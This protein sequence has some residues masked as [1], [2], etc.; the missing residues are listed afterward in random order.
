MPSA[1]CKETGPEALGGARLRADSALSSLGR[2][3]FGLQELEQ[4]I[5]AAGLGI[6]AGHVEAAEGMAADQGAGAFA[7]EVQVA[8]EEALLGGV[9]PGRVAGVDGAGEAVLGIVGE[10]QRVVEITGAGHGQDGSE[11]LL[12]EEARFRVDVGDEG[13]LN[14]IAVA[15]SGSA[16][17]EQAPLVLPD[18]DVVEDRTAGTL[19]DH[20]THVVA[21]VFT[22]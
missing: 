22:W 5:G 14:E 18:L 3:R 17:G 1:S 21:R 12:L 15:G 19:V 2:D 4:V 7:V 16:A 6:G 8:D 13:G 11:D 9:D 20:R 10:L